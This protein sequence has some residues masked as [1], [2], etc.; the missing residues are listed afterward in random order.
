V[1]LVPSG[2]AAELRTGSPGKACGKTQL[3]VY[4]GESVWRSGDVDLLIWVAATSGASVL[5]G[6]VAA[7]AATGSDHVGD[8]ESVAAATSLVRAPTA[9]FSLTAGAGRSGGTQPGS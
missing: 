7:R 6:F 2:A 4:A 8:A 9:I 5:S 1:A 3:A